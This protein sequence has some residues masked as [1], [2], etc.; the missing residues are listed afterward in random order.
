MPS[1]DQQD[2]ELS[3]KMTAFTLQSLSGSGWSL[4]GQKRTSS[5]RSPQGGETAKSVGSNFA[6]QDDDSD[7]K[8]LADVLSEAMI[9]KLV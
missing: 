8:E 7:F 6:A 3:S 9:E 2:N 4:T 1:E 5:E